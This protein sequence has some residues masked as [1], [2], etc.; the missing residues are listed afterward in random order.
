MLPPDDPNAELVAAMLSRKTPQQVDASWPNQYQTKLTP[1]QAE[2]FP[3]WATSLGAQQGRTGE[4]VQRDAYDYD[5]Q[6]AYLGSLQPDARGH[7][8]DIYKKPNHP[9][10]SDQSQYHGVDGHQGGTWGRG[11]FTPGPGNFQYQ[12]PQQLRDYMREREPATR[13][14]MPP[15]R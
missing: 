10:F 13:L 9:T 3:A 1:E 15:R 4:Q 5:I 6:G 14:I 8:G 12:T 11:T 7:L 2:A